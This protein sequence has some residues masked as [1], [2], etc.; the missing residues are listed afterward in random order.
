MSPYA[1]V[2]AALRVPDDYLVIDTETNGMQTGEDLVL[3]VQVGYALVRD[4][5]VVVRDAVTINW[6]KIM[7]DYG[8]IRKFWDRCRRTAENMRSRG[9][10][11]LLT[12]DRVAREGLDPREAW[13]VYHDLVA[14]AI[15]GGL[16]LAGHN[17]FGFDCPLLEKTAVQMGLALDIRSARILDFG[18][19]E[20][21]ISTGM[22]L[23]NGGDSI[24]DWYARVRNAPRRGKWNLSPHCV[25]KYGLAADPGLAHDAGYDCWM[26][27]QLIEAMRSLAEGSC[28]T[29][30]TTPPT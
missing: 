28:R 22:A 19:V 2:F 15:A 29:H 24:A 17:I 25:E 10:E 3:P 20:K 30:Q 26:S 7:G 8:M 16:P 6:A 12:A 5:Q 1:T 14:G 23:P 18:L 27:H 9:Q 13:P 4:R 11:C 21:A